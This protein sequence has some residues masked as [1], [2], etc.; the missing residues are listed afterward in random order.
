MDNPG[1]WTFQDM[2][3]TARFQSLRSWDADESPAHP[4]PR[5]MSTPTTHQDFSYNLESSEEIVALPRN[6]RILIQDAPNGR[7]AL[8]FR[9]IWDYGGAGGN[10]RRKQGRI[11][12]IPVRDPSNAALAFHSRTDSGSSTGDNTALLASPQSVEFA[13]EFSPYEDSPSGM[14]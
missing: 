13:S 6:Q 7:R 5:S 11:L 8:S 14:G 3:I 10:S 4:S 2:T 12:N 1:R 9:S